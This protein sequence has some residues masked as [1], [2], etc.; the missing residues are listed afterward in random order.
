MLKK[1]CSKIFAQLQTLFQIN[2][3]NYKILIIN[4]L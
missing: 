3:Q 4:Y 1:N 2:I